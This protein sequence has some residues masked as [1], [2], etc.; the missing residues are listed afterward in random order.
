MNALDLT[1][2]GMTFDLQVDPMEL[3][4]PPLKVLDTDSRPNLPSI[5]TK[6]KHVAYHTRRTLGGQLVT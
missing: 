6:T 1:W 4:D 5:R 3:D 2:P